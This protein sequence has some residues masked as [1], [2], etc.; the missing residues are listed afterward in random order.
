MPSKK[1]ASI[2]R[3][4]LPRQYEFERQFAKD[5]DRLTRAGRDD[6]VRLKYVMG[7][8][9]MNDGP[10]PPEFADHPLSGTWQGSRDCHVHGDLLLIY[11]IDEKANMVI[12]VRTGSHADVFGD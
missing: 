4:N 10:L 7:L 8:L 2:K 11:R 1:P 3:T 12:F 5:W 9:I 6:M